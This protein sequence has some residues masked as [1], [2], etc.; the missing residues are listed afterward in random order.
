MPLTSVPVPSV[1]MIEFDAD[2]HHQDAVDH[3][4]DAAGQQCQ[5]DRHA[6]R[7]A[8]L[9]VEDRQHHGRQ[10]QHRRGRQVVFTGG[11]ADQQRVGQHHQHRLRAEH[12]GEVRGAQE[13]VGFQHAEQG[14]G[15]DPG[16]QERVA[17]DQPA[18][19]CAVRGDPSPRPSSPGA[20]DP[21]HCGPDPFGPG[22][23]GPGR[24]GPR[25]SAVPA[26][27]PW[28][29]RSR[30]LASRPRLL[31]SLAPASLRCPLPAEPPEWAIGRDG[32]AGGVRRMARQRTRNTHAPYAPR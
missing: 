9:R 18:Q 8:H 14:D 32:H 21:G 10:G 11:Q 23:C 30:P 29:L 15:G 17:V 5:H 4:R 20:R 19:R 26:L 31:R 6:D 25:P 2:P 12:R 7:H 16:E 1:T 27:Q 24:C 22:R 13:R 28:R 3:A